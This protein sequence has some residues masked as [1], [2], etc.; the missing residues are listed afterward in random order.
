MNDLRLDE[1]PFDLTKATLYSDL[2]IYNYWVDLTG[3]HGGLRAVLKPRNLMPMMLLGGKGSGKTHL[4][5][6]CSAPVQAMRFHGNLLKAVN[7]EGYLGIYLLADDLNAGRFSGKGQSEEIWTALFSYYFELWMVEN[8]LNHL[9]TYLGERIRDQSLQAQIAQQFRTLLDKDITEF[10]SLVSFAEYFSKVRRSLD[11][12]INN[13]AYSRTLD[14]IDILFSPGRLVFGIPQILGKAIPELSK[15]VFV[16]L[17]DEIENFSENQQRFLNSLIRYRSGNSTIKVGTRLYGVKTYQTLGSGEPNKQNSEF[18][19]MLLDEFLRQHTEAYREFSYQLIESRLR[20]SNYKSVSST[21]DIANYFESL[22][23]S[24]LFKIPTLKFVQTSDKANK[25]RR[26]FIKL[27]KVLAY[28][29]IEEKTSNDVINN[30]QV[31]D[32]PLLEKLNVYL[33]YKRWDSENIL[34]ISEEIKNECN[35]HLSGNKEKSAAYAQNLGHFKSDLLAQLYRE[36]AQKIPYVGLDNLINLSQGIPRN[37]L[38]ILKHIHRRAVFANEKPFAG[39]VISINSQSQ[40]VIDS[41]AWFWDDAQPDNYGTEVRDA[42]ERLARLFR[43]VRYSE[44]PAECDAGTFSVDVNRLTPEAKKILEKAENWSYL[45]NIRG[46]AANKNNQRKDE[47]FQLSPM[48]VPKWGISE[49][50]R[51]TIELQPDLANS[52]FDKVPVTQFDIQLHQRVAGML[53]A[54]FAQK[55][56]T[57]SKPVPKGLFDA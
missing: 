1:N 49:H 24:D 56:D 10:D 26:Y 39:G 30:L 33:L 45:I 29:K 27:K 15:T 57:P 53:A 16:Y 43:T 41:A 18:E 7:E 31:S 12:T 11:Y 47:K 34:T 14:G 32:Y 28:A 21:K 54:N 50:R 9:Q 42:I 46:G 40:G 51:G 19:L 6:Y 2:Q 37:L 20:Q 38:G 3:E 25:L 4:M 55:Q 8:L 52:I 36:Y 17:I 13:S 48:L 5:R 22:D 35:A 44:K 23:S